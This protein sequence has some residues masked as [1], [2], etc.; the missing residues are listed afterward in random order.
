[1]ADDRI[2]FSSGVTWP[3]KGKMGALIAEWLRENAKARIDVTSTSGRG[4][5]VEILFSR[6]SG[7]RID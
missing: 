5:R 2:G 1:M 7:S 4:V 6:A 3:Q